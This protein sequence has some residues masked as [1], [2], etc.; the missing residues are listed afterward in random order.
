[1]STTASPARGRLS[2]R[3]PRLVAWRD[4]LIAHARLERLLDDDLRTV[5]GLS[6]AE[7]DTLLQLAEAP[8]RRLR[9]HQLAERVVLSRSGI[10]RLIDRLV[11]DG[12][13]ERIA[14]LSDA[15]GAEALLTETGLDRLRLASRTHLRG[16]EA[17]FLDAIAPAD[18]AAVGR[19]MHGVAAAV[20]RAGER[21]ERRAG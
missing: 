4:F 20:D 3:D 14:C 13:V 10:T 7:Y 11:R 21:E 16:I 12:S 18:L 1:M 15:R 2:A 6:L 17:H 9:M 19:A 5:H 8:G